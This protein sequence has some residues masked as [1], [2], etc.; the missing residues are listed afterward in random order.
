MCS[1]PAT[2]GRTKREVSAAG[3]EAGRH[4][5]YRIPPIAVGNNRCNSLSAQISAS[6]LSGLG[7]GPLYAGLRQAL[8]PDRSMRNHFSTSTRRLSPCAQHSSVG[9][10]HE[11]GFTLTAKDLSRRPDSGWC[12]IGLK[13]GLRMVGGFSFEELQLEPA[14]E[15]GVE[16]LLQI[17]LVDAGATEFAAVVVVDVQF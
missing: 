8:R 10:R 11:P 12:C 4:G 15:L 17:K 14:V 3:D 6:R 5:G 2:Q 9:R 13:S 16:A 1:E 7:L